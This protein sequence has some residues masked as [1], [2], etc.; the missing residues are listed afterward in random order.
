MLVEFLVLL[1]VCLLTLLP[2][3]RLIENEFLISAIVVLL[4]ELGDSVLCHL[5]LDI[6]AFA[7]ASVSMILKHLNKVLDIVRIW[8]LIKSL[9]IQIVVH[10]VFQLKIY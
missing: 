1:N 9:F 5:S 4:L 10:I 6:L 3:L 2:L 8:L 7:L